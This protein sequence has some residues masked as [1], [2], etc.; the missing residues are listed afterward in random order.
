MSDRWQVL[1][2]APSATAAVPAELHQTSADPRLTT[3]VIAVAVPA[4]AVLSLPSF[5]RPVSL[6]ADQ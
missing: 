5:S 3:T 2:G 4:N 1:V 6:P